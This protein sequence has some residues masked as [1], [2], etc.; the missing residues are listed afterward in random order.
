MISEVDKQELKSW[1]RSMMRQARQ[2]YAKYVET[3]DV[4]EW[5]NH[6]VCYDTAVC[7]MLVL[8]DWPTLTHNK[9]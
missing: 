4:V 6:Q 8:M 2:H 1:R 9:L 7:I 3:G 5:H